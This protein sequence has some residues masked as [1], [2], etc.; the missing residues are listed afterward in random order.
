[1][2]D[3]LEPVCVQI[4]AFAGEAKSSFIL[5]NEKAAEGKINE[6]KEYIKKGKE[7]LQEASKQHF[8]L[9]VNE[10][11]GENNVSLLLMHAEDQLSAAELL[12]IIAKQNIDLLSTIKE[13]GTKDE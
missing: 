12:S 3:K 1:M 4:I 9:L 7:S 5:A 11:N 8:N 13:R 2:N 6:A 10:A